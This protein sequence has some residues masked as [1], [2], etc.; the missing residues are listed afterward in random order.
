MVNLFDA[1]CLVEASEKRGRS[2]ATW[3]GFYPV[4]ESGIDF[5][6]GGSDR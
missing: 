4:K 5:R 2:T 3:C 1:S 6:L